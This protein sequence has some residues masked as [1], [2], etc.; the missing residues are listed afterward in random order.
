MR[1]VL[2]HASQIGGRRYLLTNLG[3]GLNA[4]M[5]D[6]N[7]MGR[8]NDIALMTTD[9]RRVYATMIKGWM[10]YDDTHAFG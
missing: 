5:Q 3:E 10:G 7:R 1:L 9:F 4:F 2:C 6:I 8:S